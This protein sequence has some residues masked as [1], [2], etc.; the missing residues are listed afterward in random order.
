MPS[1]KKKTS[2]AKKSLGQNFLQS[3]QIREG[4]LKEA[5]D[6]KAKNILEIGPGL[7]FLTTKLLKE[8]AQ[9]TAIELDE[10]A[11]EILNADF[12][13]K[14]NFHLIHEDFLRWDLEKHFPPGVAYSVIANIPYNITNPILRKI[15]ENTKNRPDYALL[16]VQKEVAEKICY[17]QKGGSKKHKTSVLSIAVEIFAEARYCF[18]VDRTCFS[19]APRVESAIMK[20]DFRAAPLVED[21]LMRDF[22]TVVQAGFSERRKKLK[23]TLQNFF[24]T[25][26]AKVL[27]DID[28]ELRAENLSIENWIY[29]AKNLQETRNPVK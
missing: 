25:D 1:K 21:S 3:P 5:G 14:P 22:F 9:V 28:S 18:T 2:F 13:N 20:L 7:G 11:V 26:G 19:P 17:A 15:T 12:G 6:I 10:R 8:G 24:G 23:N 29:M 4:I 27:G 16:M